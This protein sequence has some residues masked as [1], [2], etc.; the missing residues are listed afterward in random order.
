M[1]KRILSL[2]LASLMILAI[3]AFATE[4][5]PAPLSRADFIV[6]L[7]NALD[8]PV[9]DGENPFSDVADDAEYAKAVAWAAEAGVVNGMGDGNFAPEDTVT[10]EMAATIMLNYA[11]SKGAASSG[12]MIS[13]GFLDM[14]YISAWAAEGVMFSAQYQIIEAKDG[15]FDPQGTVTAEEASAWV[16]Q[17]ITLKF[18]EVEVEPPA[19]VELSALD[20]YN[21]ANAA[22]RNI[23]SVE[24]EMD[25]D[26][27]IEADG[28]TINMQIV[29][30]IRQVM[31]SETDIDM[32][33]D[34]KM[35]MLGMDINTKMFFRDGLLYT[36]MMGQKIK[37]PMPIEEAMA[38]ANTDMIDF[39]EAAVKDMAAK[40]VEGG[41]EV[42][43]TLIGAFLNDELIKQMGNMEELL[44]DDYV[45]FTFGD[46]TL[47]AVIGEDNTFKSLR[48][49]FVFDME[50]DDE[51]AQAECVIDI[52]FIKFGG[53][54]VTFPS[55][56]DDYIEMD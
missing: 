50:I 37:A 35:S 2:A 10:R 44:D 6:A 14:E 43:F 11:K 16:A 24:M 28:E 3:P 8:E 5:A 47:V 52:M 34:M 22:L 20:L 19:P 51:M 40:D 33:M 55:D 53:V 49:A 32:A 21:K 12:L 39:P 4:D 38:Q 30:N 1:K 26:M 54:I 29:S 56:L 31:R 27:T 36:E 41:V 42:S 7:Y 25:M 23:D 13:L 18:D 15:G 45:T 48:M 46:V 9:S 17:L